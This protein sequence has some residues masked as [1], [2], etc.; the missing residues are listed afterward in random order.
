MKI[1]RFF[2]FCAYSRKW[3]FCIFALDRICG[4]V[5][6]RVRFLQTL[7][8]TRFFEFSTVST[9]FSTAL[10]VSVEKLSKCGFCIKCFKISSILPQ[11][12]PFLAQS[13]GREHFLGKNSA[14][15]IFIPKRTLRFNSRF[16]DNPRKA[17][18]K[19]LKN[20]KKQTVLEV[21]ERSA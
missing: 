10:G 6:H 3:I 5:F 2:H 12:T 18:G 16:F 21:R 4:K 9:A 19:L 15:W 14:L 7:I 13:G 17:C 11:N 1:F 20:R 8:N